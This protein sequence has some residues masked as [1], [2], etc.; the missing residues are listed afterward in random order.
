MMSLQALRLDS[1]SLEELPVEIGELSYL[2][3]LTFSDNKL[4]EIPA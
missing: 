3:E 2:E 1:N 4:T